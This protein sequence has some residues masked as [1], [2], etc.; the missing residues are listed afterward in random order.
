MPTPNT[1][2]APYVSRLSNENDPSNL[3]QKLA[4]GSSTKAHIA[5]VDS[6][7]GYISKDLNLMVALSKALG[8]KVS[9][10]KVP[11]STDLTWIFVE[12]WPEWEG[13]DT[14]LQVLDRAHSFVEK[15]CHFGVEDFFKEIASTHDGDEGDRAGAR[16]KRRLV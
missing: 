8:C 7:L 14:Q 16:K 13:C 1:I 15:W 2:N 5:A 10:D 3:A 6:L 12:A 11:G 9:S 4:L